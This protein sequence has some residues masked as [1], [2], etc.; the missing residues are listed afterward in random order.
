MTSYEG[1]VKPTTYECRTCMEMAESCG[2]VPDCQNCYYEKKVKVVNITPSFG[3]TR[4]IVIYKDGVVDDIPKE[5]LRIVN[6]E[7][8]DGD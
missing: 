4:A 7:V 8:Q 2:A 6:M 1:I 3:G 5:R